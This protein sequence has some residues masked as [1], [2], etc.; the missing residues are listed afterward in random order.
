MQTYNDK[1]EIEAEIAARLIALRQSDSQAIA[2]IEKMLDAIVQALGELGINAFKSA[3][4][5]TENIT[6]VCDED[7]GV[8]L[9]TIKSKRQKWRDE[10]AALEEQIT[11]LENH[12]LSNAQSPESR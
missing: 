2:H 1:H 5:A 3:L 10:I 7:N 8:T 9:E 4:S 11:A 12:R 6:Q